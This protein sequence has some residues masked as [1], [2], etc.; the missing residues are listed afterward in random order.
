M[1]KTIAI[2]AASAAGFSALHGQE[3]I[4]VT[5]TWEWQS[6][7]VFR[8]VQ[9]AEESFTPSLDFEVNGFYAGIWAALPVNHE[10]SNEVD[11]YAGYGW[12]ITE[13]ISA[14]V[15]VT[16]Y[17]Y[18]DDQEKFFD[19]DVNAV[20]VY[21]GLA[22]E[23][24]F[25]PAF[26]VFRDFD[27]KS[28]TLELSGGESWVVAEDT[29]VDVGAHLG[30]ARYGSNGRYSVLANNEKDYFYFGATVG[31]TYAFNDYV[32]ASASV[33]W[34]WASEDYGWKAGQRDNRLFYGVAV[35]AGF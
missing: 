19:S 2:L 21:G 16:Y 22:F 32:S 9:R 25:S 33:S 7:Y 17:T 8:G 31:A 18:P 34:T 30:Y 28:W 24:P 29:T 35:T 10:F 15:G 20:E 4:S 6:A 27:R 13:L 5:T 1:K 26:Y 11:F 3:D 12:A 14:D 23:L